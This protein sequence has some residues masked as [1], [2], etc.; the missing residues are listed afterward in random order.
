[1]ENMLMHYSASNL[2]EFCLRSSIVLVIIGYD[3]DILICG[4]PEYISIIALD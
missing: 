2:E 3:I 4:E 1:M